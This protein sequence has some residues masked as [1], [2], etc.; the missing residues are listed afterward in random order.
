MSAEQIIGSNGVLQDVYLP[1]EDLTSYVGCAMRAATSST[2]GPLSVTDQ[3]GTQALF[4][5]GV[6]RNSGRF[7]VAGVRQVEIVTMG[8]VL[9]KAGTGGVAVGDSVVP[10]YAASGTDR[11]RFIA[12]GDAS[13]LADG[14]VIWGEAQTAAAE[15]GIFKLELRRRR[16]YLDGTGA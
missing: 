16:N 14:D 2:A 8:L 5:L 7:E 3:P 12:I 10:E 11:G 9:A 1:A 6:L 13:D 15:D 4:G